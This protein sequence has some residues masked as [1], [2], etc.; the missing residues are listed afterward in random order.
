MQ[1]YE[2]GYYIEIRKNGE[3]IA[4]LQVEAVHDGTV[5]DK[6]TINSCAKIIVKNGDKLTAH[7]ISRANGASK[8]GKYTVDSTLSIERVPI[9]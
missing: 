2:Y 7:L 3:P 1:R 6:R 9:F 8:K 5:A 4:E